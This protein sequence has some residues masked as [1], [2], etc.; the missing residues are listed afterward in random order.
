M[1]FMPT[2]LPSDL[3][4]RIMRRVYFVWFS[5]NVLPLLAV[6]LVLLVGVVAG[7]FTQISVKHVLL[8]AI[9]A[10]DGALAFLLFF[11]D[12]FFVKSI[13][14]QLLVAVWAVLGVF[15]LRDIRASLR[16]L[17]SIGWEELV[18]VRTG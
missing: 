5:R 3:K 7:V 9:T 13:Q 1:E 14:S 17:R 2:T 18:H 6:E 11:V 16:R 15:F 8:N 4:N 10:S 12:N